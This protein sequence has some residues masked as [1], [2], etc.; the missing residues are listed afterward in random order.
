MAMATDSARNLLLAGGF[1]RSELAQSPDPFIFR[2]RKLC[3]GHRP[4]V[5]GLI[6]G[7]AFAV[8]AI[9]ITV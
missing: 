7:L 3:R 9:A 6:F 2:G 4:L 1:G 5:L 8:L